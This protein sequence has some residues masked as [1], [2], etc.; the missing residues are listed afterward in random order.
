M[1][2]RI[3]GS[4]F[5]VALISSLG[6]QAADLPVK[7]PPPIPAIYNWTGGYLGVHVGTGFGGAR[8]SDPL[9]PLGTSIFGDNVRT[10]SFLGG[11]QI[12]YNW[13]APSSPWVFGV[14]GD[15]SGLDSV[16]TNTCLAFSG[17]FISANCRIRPEATATLTGRLGYAAG[18]DGRTLFYVKGG[19]AWARDAI[20]IATN[21]D[22]AGTGFLQP[23]PTSATISRWGGTVGAGVEQALTPAWSVKFEYDYLG[24]G[25]TNVATPGSLFQVVPPFQVAQLVTPGGFTSVSQNIQEVKIGVNYRFGADPRAGWLA[26]PAYPVNG[27]YNKAPP[28]QL[29]QVPK[30]PRN[31]RDFGHRQRFGISVDLRYD[32]ELGRVVWSC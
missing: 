14:E 13:Q 28:L 27:L 3:A 16:G 17:F 20:D 31:W 11:G 5:A 1:K 6:A 8:F 9:H 4:A 19:V 15:L 7:A 32:R 23:A 18:P 2:T 12:G 29:G 10:P 30:G 25:G 24:F 26:A 22:F 21:G